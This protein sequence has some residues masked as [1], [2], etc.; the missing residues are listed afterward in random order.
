[1]T[2]F[3]SI[4]MSLAGLNSGLQD[5]TPGVTIRIWDIGDSMMDVHPIEPGQLP[6]TVVVMPTLDLNG[7]DFHGHQDYFVLRAD[8]SLVLAQP[9]VYEFKL[10][11]D[12]GS[13]LWIAGKQVIDHGG[14]HS[15][16]AKTGRVEAN[17]Q[18]AETP[19]IEGGSPQAT[20]PKRNSDSD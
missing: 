10:I 20:P 17:T 4:I 3:L 12:D 8:G 7:N 2:M 16:T 18:G 19:C 11:S 1:M 13:E 14:L 9:G 5:E 6:N 15:A